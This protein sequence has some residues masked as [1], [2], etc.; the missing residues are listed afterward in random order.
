[1]FPFD[2]FLGDKEPQAS[3][4]VWGDFKEAQSQQRRQKLRT[5][6]E[7]EVFGTYNYFN[8]I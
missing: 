3:Y 4:S 2:T 7:F 1:M 6:E 5:L 8:P